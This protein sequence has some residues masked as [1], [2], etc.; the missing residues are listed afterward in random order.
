MSVL[1]AAERDARYAAVRP[2]FTS[3]AIG[4]G[5]RYLVSAGHNAWGWPDGAVVYT[6]TAVYPGGGE[7][8]LAAT[9]AWDEA[10]QA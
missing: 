4:W 5:R 9:Q 8:F 6:I 2:L 10:T 1:T 3:A 7:A